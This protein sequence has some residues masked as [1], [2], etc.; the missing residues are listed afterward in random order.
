MYKNNDEA[1]DLEA[2]RYL[3]MESIPIWK[4]RIVKQK[5]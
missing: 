1:I 3:I 5:R 2:K 4:K